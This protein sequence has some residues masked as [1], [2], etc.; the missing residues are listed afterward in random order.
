MKENIV[1]T[2]ITSKELLF[3]INSS[4][5]L[6][7]QSKVVGFEVNSKKEVIKITFSLDPS[8]ENI[9]PIKKLKE[10]LNSFQDYNVKFYLSGSGRLKQ[11]VVS[12]INEKL[13]LICI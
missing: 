2:K 5:F 6:N 3:Y 11:F 1:K 10:S 7:Y 4:E 12:I 8:H 9:I 13:T